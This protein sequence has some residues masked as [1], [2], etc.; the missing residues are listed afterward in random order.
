MTEIRVPTLGESVTEATIGRWFK[1]A[2]EAVAVDDD[3]FAA[4]LVEHAGLPE[5]AA[6][7]YATFGAGA[8]RGYSAV[9]SDTVRELTGK[10]PKAARQ[11]RES[12]PEAFAAGPRA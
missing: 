10:E 7:A 2:G 12:H 4:G 6:R 5:A 11:V 1:K 3:A 8:R 9:V